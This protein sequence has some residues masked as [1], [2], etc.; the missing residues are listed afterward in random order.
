MDVDLNTSIFSVFGRNKS[1]KSY[2]IKNAIIPKYDCLVFDPNGEYDQSQAD[3]YRPR[4]REYPS[5]ALENEEFLGFVKKNKGSWDLVIW[6][7]ADD[8]FP[9]NRPL[10]S[11]MANLKG[12]YRHDE[13]GNLGIGFACR[14]PAQ[15]YTDFSE[16]SH[17]IVT[18]G[19]KGANDRKKLNDI[20]EGLGDA[21][22]QLSNHEYIIVYPDQT[23]EKM[24]PLKVKKI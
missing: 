2:F 11:R 17:Y 18:F 4:S 9:L 6:D 10:F 24:P 16:L 21:A 1:G 3:V 19:S 23:F 12:K 22:Q 14:R 13:W 5:M 15:L 7:E 8:I 20:S